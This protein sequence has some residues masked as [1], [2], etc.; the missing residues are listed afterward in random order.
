MSGLAFQ[1]IRWYPELVNYINQSGFSPLHILA[2]T[3]SAFKSSS[4]LRPLD[5]LIYQCL[6][7]EEL[8]GGKEDKR[9][10]VPSRKEEEIPSIRL[11]VEIKR[12]MQRI[13]HKRAAQCQRE[14]GS[15]NESGDGIER[16]HEEMMGMSNKTMN[17]REEDGRESRPNYIYSSC[18]E[19]FNLITAVLV[20]IN[21]EYYQGL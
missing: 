5:R 15:E 13:P 1:I 10:F 17:Q 20:A 2:N 11:R 3:P 21:G 9:V 18:V 16:K 8:K 19:I 4:R 12:K 7:V 6:I 14:N